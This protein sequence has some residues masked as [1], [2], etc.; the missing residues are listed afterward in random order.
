MYIFFLLILLIILKINYFINSL[1]SIVILNRYFNSNI[2][3]VMYG[4]T[5]YL[6]N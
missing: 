5:I 6:Y 1:T 4:K 2:L 3:L